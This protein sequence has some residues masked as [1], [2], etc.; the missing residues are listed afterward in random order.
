MTKISFS[1]FIYGSQVFFIL[2]SHI[3]ISYSNL[4]KDLHEVVTTA[5]NNLHNFFL[6]VKLVK[7]NLILGFSY[8]YVQVIVFINITPQ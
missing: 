8:L 5:V 2:Y 6:H 7:L 1:F 3:E 4:L